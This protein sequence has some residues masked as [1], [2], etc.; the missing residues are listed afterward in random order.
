MNQ[1]ML[2]EGQRGAIKSGFNGVFLQP[3]STS[4]RNTHGVLKP[5]SVQPPRRKIEENRSIHRP[6]ERQKSLL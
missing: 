2:S 4:H 6:F 5:G 3:S 1:D